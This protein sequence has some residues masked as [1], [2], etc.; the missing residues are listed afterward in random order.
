[1]ID[2]HGV[3][4]QLAVAI[5]NV[6]IAIDALRQV[7]QHRGGVMLPLDAPV[8]LA[9]AD[10]FDVILAGVPVEC[11]T[12]FARSAVAPADAAPL[13]PEVGLNGL[14]GDVEVVKEVLN[15]PPVD[16]GDDLGL[17][18]VGIEDGHDRVGGAIADRHDDRVRAV[19]GDP[20]H[21][22]LSPEIGE[23]SR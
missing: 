21:S 22:V 9:V 5:A 20:L 23:P 8:V 14:V 15:P 12:R 3:P 4:P 7:V 13:P 6:S 2:V 10:G 1:M 11:R 16:G 19:D 17:A 18:V